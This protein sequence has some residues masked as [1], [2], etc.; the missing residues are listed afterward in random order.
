MW[1]NVTE[2]PESFWVDTDECRLP[3]GTLAFAYE[4]RPNPPIPAWF[5]APT[6]SKLR[7]SSHRLD[8]WYHVEE[9]RSMRGTVEE[10]LAFYSECTERGGLTKENYRRKRDWAGFSADN[11][12][13]HAF[14]GLDIY[15]HRN[16]VF[17]T[18]QFGIQVCEP[19]SHLS[20]HLTLVDRN[21]Q[22]V[23][24]RHPRTNEEYWA[25][26]ELLR[27]FWPEVDL[28]EEHIPWASLPDW[29][30]FDI[31]KGREGNTV[32]FHDE[33]GTK[34]SATIVIPLEVDPDACFTACLDSLDKLGFDG[35]GLEHPERSYYVSLA[36]NGRFRHL[37]MYSETGDYALLGLRNKPDEV[38][39]FIQ[40]YPAKSPFSE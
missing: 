31:V 24:L 21:K 10:V 19:K 2:G 7:G 37:R 25:P 8:A 20:A 34:T 33:N 11:S 18:A 3:D 23:T 36:V 15:E 16:L 12:K 14:F 28:Y 35:S 13:D 38:T 6:D 9:Y 5:A 26:A 39:F 1:I 40:Y 27:D 29:L 4:P 32:R 30:Q 17:W 22:R